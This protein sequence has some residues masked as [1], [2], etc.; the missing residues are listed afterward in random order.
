MTEKTEQLLETSLTK[1]LEVA[2]KTGQ[3]VMEQAPDL[4]KQFYLWHTARNIA[5]VFSLSILIFI[6]YKGIKIAI[7]NKWKEGAP[8]GAGIFGRRRSQSL[9]EEVSAGYS[10]GEGEA[11]V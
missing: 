7:K 3:F 8:L 4:L 2:E 9:H 6:C 1:C 5:W 11:P 10:V